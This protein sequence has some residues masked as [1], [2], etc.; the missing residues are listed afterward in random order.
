M[1]LLRDSWMKRTAVTFLWVAI[2]GLM[3]AYVFASDRTWKSDSARGTNLIYGPMAG[4]D[5]V[6]FL[7]NLSDHQRA[8]LPRVPEKIAAARAIGNHP[9]ASPRP[10]VSETEP[11]ALSNAESRDSVGRVEPVGSP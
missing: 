11:V 8:T 5:M 3:V 6:V 9:F 2:V 1:D 4:N 10:I 7:S